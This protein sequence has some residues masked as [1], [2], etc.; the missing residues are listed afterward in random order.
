MIIQLT[1]DIQ[2]P[3]AKEAHKLRMTPEQLALDSLRECFMGRE[4]PPSPAKESETLAHFLRG[5]IG[6]L[7]SS[8]HVTGGAR[9]SEASGKKFSRADGS[10][11]EVVP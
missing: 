10:T 11:L 2:Q 9:M 8:E 6:V 1:P 7:H 3:L 4:P 5:H